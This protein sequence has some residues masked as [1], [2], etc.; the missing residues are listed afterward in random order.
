MLEEFQFL[1]EEKAIEVVVT[2]TVELSDRFEDIKLFPDKLFTPIIE[3]ADEEIRETC[4]DTAKS[5]YG[6]E[7]PDV[8]IARLEKELDSDY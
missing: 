7:L 6:E 4:Y 8:V 1:G 3:G 2:N 5:M